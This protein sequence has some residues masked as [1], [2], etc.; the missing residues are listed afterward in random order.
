MSLLDRHRV[1]LITQIPAKMPDREMAQ[2]PLTIDDFEQQL[3]ADAELAQKHT[4]EAQ[5]RTTL[6]KMLQGAKVEENYTFKTEPGASESYIQAMRVCL[7]RLRQKALKENKELPRW[8]MLVIK[9]E[10][11][12][13]YDAVTL[14]RTK[15]LKSKMVESVM[16]QL[17]SEFL[18][19]E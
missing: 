7:S 15:L 9:I 11:T 16:D 18:K 12:V 6:L 5:P 3:A 17:L 13:E 10:K 19:G 4:Y 14:M 8:K 1:G 2:I